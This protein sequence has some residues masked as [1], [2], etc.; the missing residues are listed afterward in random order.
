MRLFEATATGAFLLTEWCPTLDMIFEDGK[1]LVT[2]KT[3]DEAIEKARY[4]LDHPDE[5]EAIAKAGMEH[6]L[7]HHTY[8]HRVKEAFEVVKKEELC[9]TA[10]GQLV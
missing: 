1:H 10:N 6:T 2:Y 4:Y 5:R 7:A 3:M 8:Q 9:K